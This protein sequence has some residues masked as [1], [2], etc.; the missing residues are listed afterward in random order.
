LALISLAFAACAGSELATNGTSK[1]AAKIVRIGRM[2]SSMNSTPSEAGH[3]L[4]VSRKIVRPAEAT[5]SGEVR[6]HYAVPAR[7]PIL[8]GRKD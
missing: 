4:S 2:F 1:A 8:L 5:V 7:M 3:A 6:S